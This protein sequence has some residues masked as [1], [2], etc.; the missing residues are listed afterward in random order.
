VILNLSKFLSPAKEKRKKNIL[1]AAR[2]RN[3]FCLDAFEGEELGGH[4]LAYYYCCASYP[5]PSF[6]FLRKE[7]LF[8]R[9]CPNS[10]DGGQRKIRA[11][12]QL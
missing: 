6:F 1:W 7:F 12:L 10:I 2:E 11:S 3:S 4:S 9:M 5:F 8:V